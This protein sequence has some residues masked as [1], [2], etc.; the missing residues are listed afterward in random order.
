L[1]F[2]ASSRLVFPPTQVALQICGEQTFQLLPYHTLREHAA[3]T[4]SVSPQISA[5]SLGLLFRA[6]LH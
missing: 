5:Q 6:T 1:Q 4:F 3:D 2:A